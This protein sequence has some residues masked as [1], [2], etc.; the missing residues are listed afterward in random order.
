MRVTVT[1]LKNAS[2]KHTSTTND[3]G[4]F[5]VEDIIPFD[6]YEV[7]VKDEKIE[8]TPLD[9]GDNA[10]TITLNEGGTNF[11]VSFT[12]NDNFKGYVCAY[13]NNAPN[14]S[15]QHLT[16][17]IIIKNTGGK[18]TGDLD[19]TAVTYQLTSANGL[20]VSNSPMKGILGTIE[21]GRTKEISI[22]V[23]CSARSINGDFAFKTI[24]VQLTDP[25]HDRTWQDSISVK[26]Y[27]KEVKFYLTPPVGLFSILVTPSGAYMFN[28]LSEGGSVIQIPLLTGDYT[29]VLCGATA[30][31]EGQYAFVIDNQLSSYY[32]GGIS[33]VNFFSGFTDT[34]RYEPNDTEQTATKITGN[35]IV[36]YLHKGDFDYYRFRLAY[37]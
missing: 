6:T 20:S 13:P 37:Y 34:A 23:T 29:L 25:I 19:A 7:E 31:S 5:K 30:D 4:E 12:Q 16:G 3:N 18:N 21:P 11:K 8:F 15:D 17:R 36:A 32:P 22:S 26:F 9:G 28:T 1:N 2:D 35:E 14:S 10:G 24:G 27:K 33:T